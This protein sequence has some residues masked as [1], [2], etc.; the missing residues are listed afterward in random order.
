MTHRSRPMPET[1]RASAERRG[2]A[3]LARVLR[4]LGLLTATAFVGLLVY[5]VMA[6]SP[7]R[8]IDSALAE[9]RAVPAPGFALDVLADGRPGPLSPV[10]R[11]AAADGRVAL[12]ELRGTPVVVNFWA[13]WCDP[14]R[15]EAPVLERGWRAARQRG[16]L[17]V[18][19]NQQ[20][21][22][23]DARA[24]MRHFRHDFPSIRDPTSATSRRWGVTGI[25]ETFFISREG[26]V[27]GHVIGTVT[28]AQLTDGVSAALAGRP[29]APDDGGEQKATR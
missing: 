19:L 2:G 14:C 18:G 11:R 5:G 15:V 29:R 3:R 4:A 28:A 17:F 21:V 13:S 22:R 20:D 23:E 25:P 8:T 24:F 6:R 9:R 27:V 10:W 1:P 7:D 12:K 26:N 16:V